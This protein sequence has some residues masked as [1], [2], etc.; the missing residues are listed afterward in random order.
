ML[1]IVGKLPSLKLVCLPIAFNSTVFVLFLFQEGDAHP[2]AGAAAARALRGE[3]AA[4]VAQ[5]GRRAR[6][7]APGGTRRAGGRTPAR[8]RGRGA[9][10]AGVHEAA[11]RT[12]RGIE[13]AG[14]RTRARRQ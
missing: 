10:R 13:V 3:R 12:R 4:L 5:R 2:G 8:H 1:G 9:A 6:A 11:A 14:A 7:R